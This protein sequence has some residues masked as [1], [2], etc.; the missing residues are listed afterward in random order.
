MPL[1]P[2]PLVDTVQTRTTPVSTRSILRRFEK[3]MKR[4]SRSRVIEKGSPIDRLMERKG[5]ES[6]FDNSS[7]QGYNRMRLIEY[8]FMPP[9][10]RN[11]A[12]TNAGRVYGTR[13][14]RRRHGEEVQAW[15]RPSEDTK[16]LESPP[17]HTIYI[18]IPHY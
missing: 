9:L 10:P 13:S 4:V 2:F 15:P 18:P 6:T 7:R 11:G 5:T 14:G 12:N 1:R 3:N 16:P 17:I 8:Q